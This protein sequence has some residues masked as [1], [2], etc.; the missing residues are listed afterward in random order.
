MLYLTQLVRNMSEYCLVNRASGVGIPI[1]GQVLEHAAKR[2]H[3]AK[4]RI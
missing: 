4:S 3:A 1:Q 2:F